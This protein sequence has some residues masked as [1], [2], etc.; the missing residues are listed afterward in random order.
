MRGLI[1][2]NGYVCSLDHQVCSRHF[3]VHVL[4]WTL[5]CI[6]VAV[7]RA[8][9][10]C[11]SDIFS[12]ASWREDFG[13][14]LHQ[15]I[16]AASQTHLQDRLVSLPVSDADEMHLQHGTEYADLVNVYGAGCNADNMSI[17]WNVIWQFAWCIVHWVVAGRDD[18][19]TGH[20]VS[21]PLYRFPA[22]L[23]ASAVVVRA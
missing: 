5:A 19:R 23:G 3:I 22:K 2:S 7:V 17:L 18:A 16:A 8:C 10:V 6:D 1:L 15:G 4:S 12:A 9:G 21:I 13:P 14:S 11:G 20:S